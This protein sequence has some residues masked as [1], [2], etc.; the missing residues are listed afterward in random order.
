M[1]YEYEWYLFDTT[2][3]P[4]EYYDFIG[5]ESLGF[6]PEDLEEIYYPEDD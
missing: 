5:K 4:Q 6:T 3:L 1:L 2:E